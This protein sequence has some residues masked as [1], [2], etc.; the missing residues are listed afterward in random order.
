MSMPVWFYLFQCLHLNSTIAHLSNT[1]SLS[2]SFLY[3]GNNL[4][5][6]LF[7]ENKCITARLS[8]DIAQDIVT[9]NVCVPRSL[10]RS[11]KAYSNDWQH[12]GSQNKY[13]GDHF[14]VWA[15]RISRPRGKVCLKSLIIQYGHVIYV[16]DQFLVWIQWWCPFCDQTNHI[17]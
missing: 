4:H 12:Y 9:F 14:I 6:K 3:A 17:Q 16:L 1:H 5:S 2:N 10:L 15:V 7:D 11:T 8:N 13:Q